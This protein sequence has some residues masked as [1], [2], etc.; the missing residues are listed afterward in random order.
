M[1]EQL[2]WAPDVQPGSTHPNSKKETAA[3]SSV[4]M[5]LLGRLRLALGAG[6]AEP[7]C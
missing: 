2:W 7:G 3:S 4:K 1:T 6:V 5:A